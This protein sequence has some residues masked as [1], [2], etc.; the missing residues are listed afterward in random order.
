LA[1]NLHN[2]MQEL[3]MGERGNKK[4][5]SD[6]ALQAYFQ[7]IKN[8]PLLS[9]EEELA[10]S[11]KIQKGDEEAKQRLE[12]GAVAVRLHRTNGDMILAGVAPQ[13]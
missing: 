10:L 2:F 4:K 12:L 11:R 5:E 13:Q 8:T 7:Q 3:E 6:N 1:R 9:F